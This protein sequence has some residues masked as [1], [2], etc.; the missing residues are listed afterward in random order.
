MNHLE[1]EAAVRQE[2]SKTRALLTPWLS[3]QAPSL[4]W[5]PPNGGWS[6]RE[7][8][9]HICLTNHY[10]L[11]LVDK[12]AEKCL[13]R[14][15]RGEE[16]VIP[17]AYAL[18]PEG[19]DEVGIFQSFP[20]HRPAHMDPRLHPLGKDPESTFM[21][22]LARCEA[23]LMDLSGGWGS[24]HKTMMSVNGIGKLDVYQYIVFICRHAQRHCTQ[25]E[26]N[27]AAASLE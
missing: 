17:S 13:K 23:L 1:I 10:L 16:L 2:I 3:D 21:E 15:A 8:L 12:A 18:F 14:K 26:K 19:L 5:L 7:V 25:M 9:E 4:D 11:L 27:A 6:S 20:W 22:Q 24:C